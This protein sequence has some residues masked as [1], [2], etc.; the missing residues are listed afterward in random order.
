VVVYRNGNQTFVF[1]KSETPYNESDSNRGICLSDDTSVLQD[2]IRSTKTVSQFF[3]KKSRTEHRIR[4][5]NKENTHNEGRKYRRVQKPV[6]KYKPKG[7]HVLER[8]KHEIGGT[9]VE[10][11]IKLHNLRIKEKK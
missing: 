9:V 10:R 2:C 1:I 3:S 5:I 8:P 11:I 4:K 7:K 6:L